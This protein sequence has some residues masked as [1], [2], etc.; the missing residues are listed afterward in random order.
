MRTSFAVI[1]ALSS[2]S[3]PLLAADET[4][5]HDAARAGMEEVA[6]G[7]L[8]VSK[9][10][11]EG[12]KKFGRLMIDEHGAAN[13][14]LKAAAARSGVELPADLAA[15]PEAEATRRKLELLTGKAF[16]QAYVESQSKLH[17]KAVRLLEKE[18]ASGSDPAAKAWARDALPMMKRHAELVGSVD[19]VPGEHD[20]EH[21]VGTPGPADA[22]PAPAMPR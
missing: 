21:A 15:D 4:F 14:K 20:V 9:G 18:I 8:G 22:P 19:A 16:D 17:A 13:A 12:V 7:Q 10:S 3:A 6:L 5:F 2:W 1:I 11:S